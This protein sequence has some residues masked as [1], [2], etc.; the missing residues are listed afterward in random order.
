[1]NCVPQMD[2]MIHRHFLSMQILLEWHSLMTHWIK[3][4]TTYCF[5]NPGFKHAVIVCIMHGRAICSCGK[6]NTAPSYLA[7]CFLYAQEPKFESQLCLWPTKA[8]S[9]PNSYYCDLAVI[10]LMYMEGE[11]AWIS[12][13][14]RYCLSV[15]SA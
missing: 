10:P 4:P 9:F 7:F 8:N 15:E 12:S 5:N 1:M 14:I 13:A 2:C 3:A 11:P 6:F